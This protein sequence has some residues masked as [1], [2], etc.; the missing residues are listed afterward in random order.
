MARV[1]S[2]RLDITRDRDSGKYNCE[3]SCDLVFTA[4]EANEMEEGLTFRLSGDLMG[5]DWYVY[6]HPE[7]SSDRIFR[8]IPRDRGADFVAHLPSQTVTGPGGQNRTVVLSK[9]L[10]RSELDEDSEAERDAGRDD[11]HITTTYDEL[12]A[13]VN[14][15]NTYTQI[16][17]NRSSHIVRL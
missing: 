10:T 13:Q 14:L 9:E 15:R 3:A 17:V 5:S 1:R 12:F 16:E 6:E 2:V 11:S 7:A 4:Y 8:S